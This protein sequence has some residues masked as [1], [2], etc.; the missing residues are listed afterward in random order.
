MSHLTNHIEIVN[1]NQYYFDYWVVNVTY[2]YIQDS[3]LK[4]YSTDTY[5]A[6]SAVIGRFDV[7]A[8]IDTFMD[9]NNMPCSFD[10]CIS[11]PSIIY[12]W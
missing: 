12:I 4:L 11:Q 3:Y 1:I 10:T 6:D 9:R 2:D 5:F 8:T 7:H